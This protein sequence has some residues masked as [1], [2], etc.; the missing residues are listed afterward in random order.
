MLCRRQTDSKDADTPPSKKKRK[1]KDEDRVSSSCPDGEKIAFSQV[2]RLTFHFLVRKSEGT[3]GRRKTGSR[4]RF[5][6]PP[7]RRAARIMRGEGGRLSF[8]VYDQGKVVSDLSHLL[9]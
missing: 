4:F 9:C 2:F 6:F 7:R 5:P 1:Y 3:D 8:F